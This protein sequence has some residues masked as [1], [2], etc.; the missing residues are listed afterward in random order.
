LT[1]SDCSSGIW[2][3]WPKNGSSWTSGLCATIRP[4]SRRPVRRIEMPACEAPPR[5]S[6]KN[7]ICR[8]PGLDRRIVQA[9]MRPFSGIRSRPRF[10]PTLAW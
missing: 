8:G 7:W 9:T 2:T 6:L 10:V 4:Y 5:R 3:V 1:A